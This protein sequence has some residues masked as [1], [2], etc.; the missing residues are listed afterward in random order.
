MRVAVIGGG[1]AGLVSAGFAASYGADVDLYEKNDRLGVKLRITG[2]GR[3]NVTNNCTREEFF[4]NVVSNPKFLYSAYSGFDSQAVMSFFESLGV[5]LKTERGRRVFPVSDKA[6]DVAEAL[7]RFCKKNGV[8][9]VTKNVKKIVKDGGFSVICS[10]RV[11]KYDKVIIATGGASYPKTGSTGDGY[12]FAGAFGHTVV[13]REPSLVPLVCEDGLCKEC[14]GLSLRNVTLSCT[15]VQSGKTVYKE[16]GEMLFT[17]N[18]VS[19]P[20]VL[21]ASAH[22]KNVQPGKYTLHIDLKPALDEKT[23]DNRILSDFSGSLNKNF[24]NSLAA[25]LPNKLIQPFIQRTGIDPYKKVNAV[26]AAERKKIVSVLK[27]LS[28]DVSGYAPIAEAVITRGGV[29]VKEIDPKTMQ[30]KLV[31]GLYFAGEVIDVDAYTG[32]YNL[33]IAFCTAYAAA[34]GVINE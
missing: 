2:K 1:A 19:G 23:L 12:V 8:K 13:P 25:L 28:L 30:S 20:L 34:R 11:E 22:L 31:P 27:D 18:G 21:S 17:K 15:E 16:Q 5:P 33:Q 4:D 24:S 10:D 6:S 7:I 9:T 3:C 29:S 14:E 32:G 26:T